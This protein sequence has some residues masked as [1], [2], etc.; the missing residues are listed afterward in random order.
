MRLDDCTGTLMESCQDGPSWT[1]LPGPSQSLRP[2]FY[3]ERSLQVLVQRQPAQG[4]P[5]GPRLGGLAAA[6]HR[7]LVV[8]STAG[9]APR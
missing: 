2:F 4:S 8:R 1:A 6:P 3:A 5:T 7:P 9:P